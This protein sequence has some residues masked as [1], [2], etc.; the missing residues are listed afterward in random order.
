MERQR[1]LVV[2][3]AQTVRNELRAALE[4][5]GYEVLEAA[6]GAEA[7]QVLERDLHV[8]LM[9]VDV[10]MPVMGGVDFLRARLAQP[11]RADIP[12]MMLTT[13]SNSEVIRD[14]RSAGA[15]AWMVKPFKP[16]M[17]LAA[18]RRLISGPDKRA[19]SGA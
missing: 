12:V 10:N 7:L 15:N 17:L 9:I 14:A 13:E 16:L 11:G 4:P 2:D 3:D 8:A 6:H 1:I 19:A 18:V 5:E